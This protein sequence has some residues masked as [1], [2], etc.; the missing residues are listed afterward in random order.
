MAALGLDDDEYKTLEQ[1]LARFSQL[2]SSIQ[3]LKQDIL[4]SNPLPPPSSLQA[5]A[6]ILQ[7]NLQT[8]LDSLSENNELFSRIAIH[9]STSYPGRTQEN[10]LTQLLRKKLEPDVEELV[11]QGRETAHLATPEGLDEL[12]RIWNELRE[13]THERIATYVRDEA[14]DVYTAEE[15]AQG[16]ENVRTGLKRDLEEESEDEEG[17]EED[18]EDAEGAQQ[19]RGPEIETLLWF[20]TRGDFEVPPNVEYMRKKGKI[21]KGLEGVN[22]PSGSMQDTAP[23]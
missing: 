15:R 18:E 7:R 3:S 2:S 10:V 6:Q 14:G 16:I 13:W 4:R 11:S 8:V 9:P 5:S 12:Q 19:I 1:T 20:H 21:Y 22:I 17:D 23:S